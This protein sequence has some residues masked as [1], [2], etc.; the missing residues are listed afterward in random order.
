MRIAFDHDYKKGYWDYWTVTVDNFISASFHRPI[1][2]EQLEGAIGQSLDMATST[3]DLLGR[4][5]D[6]LHGL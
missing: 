3:S 4:A 5:F 1:T 2:L 6:A